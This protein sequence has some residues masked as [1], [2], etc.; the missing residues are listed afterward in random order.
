[1]IAGEGL[2]PVLIVGGPLA[3]KLLAHHRSSHD[4]AE[5]V[6]DLLGARETA[7]VAVNDNAIEAV[8]NEDKKIAEQL[9]EEFHG[10]PP[11]THQTWTGPAHGRGQGL[12]SRG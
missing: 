2:D 12:S 3:Q 5:E 9:D 8:I 7:Q 10:H 11:K 6:D 1:V 4:L